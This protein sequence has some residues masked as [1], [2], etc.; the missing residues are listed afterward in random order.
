[1]STAGFD[2]TLSFDAGF[3]P[4]AM[5][6]NPAF[7]FLTGFVP[8]KLKDLFK[9]CEY[10]NANSAHI[11]AALQKFGELVVTDI[12]ITTPNAA[13]R[14][15]YKNI[16]KKN[17]RI[18][19]ALL[20]ALQ[21]RRVYGNHFVTVYRPFQR[22][23]KCPVCSADTNATEVDYVFDLKYLSFKY[24]CP[25]CHSV[26]RGEVIDRPTRD[27]SRFNIVKLDPKLMDI[28]YNSITGESVYYYKI[29]T[30]DV[31]AIKSGSKHIINGMPMEILECVR[32]SKTF[33][34]HP[35]ALYHIKAV[36]PS[37][38]D[39]Q[40]GFPPLISTIKLFLY[41]MVLRKANEAIALEHIVP[42]RILHPVLQ[43]TGNA[44]PIQSIAL[45]R[46][47]QEMAAGIRQW[48]RDPL[49]M[50][51]APVPLGVST[52][53]GDGR[54]MLTL[55]EVQEA[56]KATMAALGV[57]LEFLYGGLSKAGM[58]A[59]IRLIQNMLQK[60]TDDA[61]GLLQWFTDQVSQFLG[62]ER[63]E[64]SLTPMQLVDDT[65][66]KNMLASLAT[67]QV[68]GVPMV[69]ASTIAERLGVDP[70]E[71]RERRFQ[72][73]MAEA[74]LQSR[75]Q[76]ETQKLQQ[77]LAAQ[78]QTTAQGLNYDQQAVISQADGLVEQLMG[79]DH[80]ARRSQLHSLMTEDYVLYSV[81]IQRLENMRNQQEQEARSQMQ[82]PAA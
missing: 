53:G 15:T 78:V 76:R 24:S 77:A 25:G 64:A 70:E 40:W 37:G 19:E 71:E 23:L 79:L 55:G 32:D 54:A 50:L 45:S 48:R 43:G 62:L 28:D 73:T 33:R 42:M 39:P 57:P 35:G 11:Y 36:G 6:P 44:D 67:G 31:D 66:S 60:D 1:M 17:L 10:L 16:Y 63:V 38:L 58:E 68:G 74:R 5:H 20:R 75:I 21:D 61:N 30:V 2:S 14:T 34:F 4:A 22:F 12:E 65:E 46:W 69:D 18:K 3:R 72:T 80:G 49:H 13:L 7:D 27:I 47:Q 81:V 26:V 51:M 82:Q 29:P 56:D 9:W 8:R 52:L 59:T 41:S